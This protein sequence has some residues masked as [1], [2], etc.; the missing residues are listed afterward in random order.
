MTE[1]QTV[2]ALAEAVLSELGTHRTDCLPD[3]K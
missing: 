2:D 1:R 3:R